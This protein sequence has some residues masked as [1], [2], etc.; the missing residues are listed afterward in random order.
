M[1]ST[2]Q[3]ESRRYICII[4]NRI[5]FSAA[6]KQGKKLQQA[7]DNLCMSQWRLGKEEMKRNGK[8]KEMEVP[9]MA[10]SLIAEL[11]HTTIKGLALLQFEYYS[12]LAHTYSA[13][14]PL[15]FRAQCGCTGCTGSAPALHQGLP[16]E[17]QACPVP[18]GQ[19]DVQEVV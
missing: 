16:R 5:L 17:V 2:H 1:I 11:I 4:S 10:R 8:T 18:H 15:D 13:G 12:N 3:C 6:A 19:P 7:E 9:P 14:G